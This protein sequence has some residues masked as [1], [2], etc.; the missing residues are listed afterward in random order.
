MRSRTLTVRGIP[1]TTLK[2]LRARAAQN[3]RSLNGELLEILDATAA[4]VPTPTPRVSAVREPATAAYAVE[5]PPK[6]GFLESL[7]QAALAEVC[8]RHH[9]VWL[10]VFG[11]H[12]RGDAHPDSDVDVVVDFA[13]GKTPGFGLVRLAAALQPLLGGRCVDLLTRRGLSPRLRDSILSSART[14]HGQ[15]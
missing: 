12:A 10:A 4:Q 5:A 1:D 3:R 11:S 13:A 2:R 15:P 8:R 6:I 14:L 9:I 7:D